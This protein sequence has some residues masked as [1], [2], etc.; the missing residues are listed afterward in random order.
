[1]TAIQPEGRFGVLNIDN[2][3]TTITS[4]KEKHREDGGWINGGYM[5]LEPEIFD[6]IKGD[7]TILEKEPLETLAKQNMLN[8]YKY[9]GFWKCMDTQRDKNQLEQLLKNDNAKWKVW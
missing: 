6:Y 7:E 9:K 1:M 8:A 4:F 5:V 3:N 2:D